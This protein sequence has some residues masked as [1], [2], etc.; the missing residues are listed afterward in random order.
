MEG[1]LRVGIMTTTHQSGN[2]AIWKTHQIWLNIQRMPALPISEKLSRI[3]VATSQ[4][5]HYIKRANRWGER[6]NL[7]LVCVK[8][9]LRPK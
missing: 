5:G 9:S 2:K 6:L 3:S 8:F 7:K 4:E 1:R